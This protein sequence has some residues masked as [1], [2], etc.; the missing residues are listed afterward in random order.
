MTIS[1]LPFSL[2]EQNDHGDLQN[3]WFL[4]IYVVVKLIQD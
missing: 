1:Y 2:R 4:R 3:L